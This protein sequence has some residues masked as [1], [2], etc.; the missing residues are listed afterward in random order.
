MTDYF[1]HTRKSIIIM[2][3]ILMI[4]IFSLVT[5]F[6]YVLNDIEDVSNRMIDKKVEADRLFLEHADRVNKGFLD[7]IEEAW[8]NYDEKNVE[9]LANLILPPITKSAARSVIILIYDNK[10]KQYIGFVDE[11]YNDVIEKVPFHNI[12]LNEFTCFPGSFNKTFG[13]HN[14]FFYE[15]RELDEDIIIIV[16]FDEQIMYN[17]FISTTDLKSLERLQ[18]QKDSLVT[19]ITLFMV[20]I[21]CIGFFLVWQASSLRKKFILDAFCN[22]CNGDIKIKQK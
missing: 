13:S 7:T 9:V 3:I 12:K 16:G 18:K 8:N 10:N 4:S 5:Y 15:A 21:V 2:L 14:R 20:F 19:A 17:N 6:S 22:K 11:R 1:E